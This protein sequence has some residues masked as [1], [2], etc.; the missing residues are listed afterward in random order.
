QHELD[1]VTDPAEG[2]AFQYRI[3]ELYEKHLDDIARAIELYRDLLQ[4]MSDHQ[5]TL[6]ALEGIKS[7]TKDPLGAALVLEPIYD[8]TGEY[9][10]LISVLEVQVKASDDAYHKVELLHRIARLHEEML[11]DHQS[12]F[13]T[14]ARAAQA[15][16]ANEDTL[17]NFERLAVY[18]TRWKEV[19][20]LYDQELAKLSDDPVRFAE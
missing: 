19:A 17:A 1:I 6:A 12:A 20:A 15:D 3:A 4:Q 14:Y 18:V 8:A 16:I 9:L 2:I 7:G 11:Q 10:K 5:P 13:D